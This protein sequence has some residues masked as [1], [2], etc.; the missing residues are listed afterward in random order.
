MAMI[1]IHHETEKLP[2]RDGI[3]FRGE[4]SPADVAAVR[5]IVASTGFF[6]PAEIDV[7]VELVQE[8]LAKGDESTY[9]FLFADD[10]D[11]VVGYT[12]YGPIPCTASS[13]DLYWIAVHQEAHGRGIG[14]ELMRR[15]QEAIIAAGG[16]RVY[17]ETSSRPQ[18]EP[19]QRFYLACGY[20]EVARLADFYAP[21]DGKIIYERIL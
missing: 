8:R 18:Y 1:P 17:I 19:T 2:R 13:F 15:T 14:R 20:R 6:S 12:C 3:T 11:H 16:D 21:G 10:A 5:A 9:R 7:A 4:V